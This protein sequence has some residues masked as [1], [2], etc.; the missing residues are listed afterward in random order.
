MV[1][2]MGITLVIGWR[3][4]PCLFISLTNF[5]G[6]HGKAIAYATPYEPSLDPTEELTA[7]NSTLQL[8]GIVSTPLAVKV[9]QL[10][11]RIK[12]QYAFVLLMVLGFGF[13]KLS[14]AFFYRRLFVTAR[15]TLFDRATKI[16]I[17]IVLLWTVSFFFGL[18]FSCGTHI[19]ANWGS[20]Q[21]QVLY[22]GAAVNLGNA[23][24]VSDL[25]TD[26]MILCLPLPVV[27]SLCAQNIIPQPALLTRIDLAP[28]YGHGKEVDGH[29][30]FSHWR[31]VS[32]QV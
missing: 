3:L 10:I 26:V 6:L 22:C 9:L 15:Q 27:S 16:A 23:M 2:G 19:S 1:I 17:I 18:L 13:I 14:I 11:W 5:V 28:S 7:V 12:V 20:V 8:M 4:C 29:W 32:H 30:N 21:D 24:V 25:I 31:C